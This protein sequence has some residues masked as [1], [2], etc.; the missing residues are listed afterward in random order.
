MSPKI[1]EMID[2]DKPYTLSEFREFCEKNDN[3]MVPAI[4]N[5]PQATVCSIRH[6]AKSHEKIYGPLIPLRQKLEH[7]NLRKEQRL[8]FEG[9]YQDCLN[10]PDFTFKE[11]NITYKLVNGLILRSED[12]GRKYCCLRR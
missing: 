7:E 2:F 12:E 1:D 9:L 4:G 3:L 8:E 5:K 6:L 10:A 11:K